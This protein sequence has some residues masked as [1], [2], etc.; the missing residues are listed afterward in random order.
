M[1]EESSN[2]IKLSVSKLREGD[3]SCA[4]TNA[5]MA[6]AYLPI[7]DS[8]KNRVVSRFVTA[9]TSLDSEDYEYDNSCVEH[10]AQIGEK[11]AEDIQKDDFSVQKYTKSIRN[12]LENIELVGDVERV[13]EDSA[14]GRMA[15]NI[16]EYQDSDVR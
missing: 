7:I 5:S 3:I 1:Y 9:V 8:E 16:I 4:S 13:P 15:R 2:Y 11:L 12:V 14:W 10:L 6:E